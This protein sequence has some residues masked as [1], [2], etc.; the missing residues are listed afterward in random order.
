MAEV[1]T[2][3]NLY[4]VT[5]LGEF[6]ETPWM[7]LVNILLGCCSNILRYVCEPSIEVITEQLMIPAKT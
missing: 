5:D 7:S 4:A 1:T 3:I 6:K 2:L